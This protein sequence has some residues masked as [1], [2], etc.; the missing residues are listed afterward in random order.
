MH[1]T[2]P[3]EQKMQHSEIP[4]FVVVLQVLHL[5]LRGRSPFVTVMG[6]EPNPHTGHLIHEVIVS[7]VIQQYPQI[8]PLIQG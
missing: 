3:Y 7:L 4:D 2:V 8:K 6:T 1:V 5:N